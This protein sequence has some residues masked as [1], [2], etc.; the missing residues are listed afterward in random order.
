LD[1]AGKDA[2]AKQL[3]HALCHR[4][5]RRLIKLLEADSPED[6]QRR[7]A[8][9]LVHMAGALTTTQAGQLVWRPVAAGIDV[10]LICASLLHSI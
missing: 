8:V 7:T 4:L 5:P 10:V 2:H 1:F 3:K 9:H 6:L